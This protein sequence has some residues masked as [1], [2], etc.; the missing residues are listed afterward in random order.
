MFPQCSRQ[1]GSFP[2]SYVSGANQGS[3]FAGSLQGAFPWTRGCFAG[4]EVPALAAPGVEGAAHGLGAAVSSRLALSPSQS[5]AGVAAWQVRALDP[6]VPID[7]LRVAG[8]AF[9]PCP[10]DQQARVLPQGRVRGRSGAP[11]WHRDPAEEARLLG[12]GLAPS[13]GLGVLGAWC[14]R[15]GLQKLVVRSHGPRA[16]AGTPRGRRGTRP[17]RR[18]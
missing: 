17:H 2:H 12:R 7:V 8:P 1:L 10:G 15:D 16:R 3:T 11:R 13:L 18:V 14:R 6:S 4:D 5:P 9:P